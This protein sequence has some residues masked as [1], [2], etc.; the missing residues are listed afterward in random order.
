MRGARDLL[1]QMKCTC[2]FR[3]RAPSDQSEGSPGTT[4]RSAMPVAEPFQSLSK[5]SLS[6]AEPAESLEGTACGSDDTVLAAQRFEGSSDT[7][8]ASD[9]WAQDAGD[10]SPHRL[11]APAGEDQAEHL[12]VTSRRRDNDSNGSVR[13]ALI[14]RV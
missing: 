6:A 13:G 4:E 2:C 10:A 14:L 7:V 9:A 1:A 11:T 3:P 5:F 8:L 12:G